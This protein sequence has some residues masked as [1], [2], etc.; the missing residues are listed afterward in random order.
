M[1]RELI[2]LIKDEV[3]IYDLFDQA[4]PPIKYITREKESQASCP[5][6]GRDTKKSLRVYPQTNSAYCFTCAQSWD[7]I[8]F[9][10]Q[11]NEWWKDGRLDSGRAIHDLSKRYDLHH[12]KPDWKEEL[13][14]SLSSFSEK[15]TRYSDYSLDKRE[16]AMLSLSWVVSKRINSLLPEERLSLWPSIEKCWDDFNKID[17]KSDRWKYLSDTWRENL[18]FLYHM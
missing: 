12:I 15:T 9:W 7:V 2:D 16:K 3:S 17:I 10:A 6:H 18:D 14:K 8:D 4:Q 11:I 1:N 5:F 13:E